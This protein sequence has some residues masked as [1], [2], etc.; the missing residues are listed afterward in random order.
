MLLFS[1]LW[2]PESGSTNFIYCSWYIFRLFQSRWIFLESQEVNSWFSAGTL[3][4]TVTLLHILSQ[5]VY[6]IYGIFKKKQKQR[7][8]EF[9]DIPKKLYIILTIVLG[10]RSEIREAT[11]LHVSYWR[12]NSCYLFPFP[13]RTPYMWPGSC[14]FSPNQWSDKCE[15]KMNILV[16]LQVPLFLWNIGRQ[17]N[18]SDNSHIIHFLTNR[19]PKFHIAS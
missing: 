9:A 12:G 10:A 2:L 16:C 19:L 4:P 8:D 11:L 5:I 15:Q 1:M 17:K 6:T 7:K 3:A 18:P 13:E 14:S